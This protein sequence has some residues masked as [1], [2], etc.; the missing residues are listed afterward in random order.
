VLLSREASTFE[1]ERV[2][3]IVIAMSEATKQYYDDEK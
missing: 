1:T 3:N 2:Q